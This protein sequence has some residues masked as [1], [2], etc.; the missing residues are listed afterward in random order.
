M[1]SFLNFQKNL[2]CSYTFTKVRK[3]DAQLCKY[4]KVV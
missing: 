1:K 4:L 2:L 3:Y